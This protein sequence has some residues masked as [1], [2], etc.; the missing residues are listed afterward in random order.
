[1]SQT[2]ATSA[3]VLRQ[4]GSQRSRKNIN[5]ADEWRC[6][7]LGARPCRHS[8]CL[9]LHRRPQALRTRVKAKQSISRCPSSKERRRSNTQTRPHKDGVGSQNYMRSHSERPKSG[10]WR[11]P[12][13]CQLLRPWKGLGSG[14]WRGGVGSTPSYSPFTAS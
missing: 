3:K 13:H 11:N 12:D 5:R 10:G 7:A 14:R 4:N 1:M 8:A 2:E 9:S 6:E